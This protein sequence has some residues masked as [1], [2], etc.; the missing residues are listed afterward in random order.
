[1]TGW[2]D[3]YHFGKAGRDAWGER[4]L[5]MSVVVDGGVTEDNIRASYRRWRSTISAFSEYLKSE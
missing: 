3:V 5:Q 2:N 1:A 4:A